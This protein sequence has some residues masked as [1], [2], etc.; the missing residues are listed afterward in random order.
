MC[1]GG[2]GVCQDL[3]KVSEGEILARGVDDD[4]RMT[5]LTGVFLVVGKFGHGR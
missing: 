3:Y 1:G 2:D 4:I 5:V